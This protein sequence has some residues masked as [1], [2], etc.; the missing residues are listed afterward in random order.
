MTRTLAKELKGR[1]AADREKARA[2]GD[3]LAEAASVARNLSRGLHPITLT[4][5]GFPG[6][7][8]TDG[9]VP[10]N[11]RFSWPSSKKLDLTHP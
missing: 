9:R 7:R 4:A 3:L 1:S 6:A 10:Q 8:G 2:L 11:V 5:N